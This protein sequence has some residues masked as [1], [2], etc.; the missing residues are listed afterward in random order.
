ML[1]WFGGEPLMHFDAVLAISRHARRVAEGAGVMSVLHMTTNGYGL[2]RERSKALV[3]AGV[4]DFQITLDGPAETHNRLRV[5]QNGKGTYDRVFQN[6]CALASI[7][8]ELKITL[9]IN[10]N[11]TNIDAIPTLLRAFPLTI[12]S[13]TTAT[14]NSD[15]R[16]QERARFRGAEC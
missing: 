12:R 4:H 8:G 14:P 9:R 2:T 3:R 1:Y 6:V 15:I 16:L 10:F 13:H 5:L 7:E 11:H